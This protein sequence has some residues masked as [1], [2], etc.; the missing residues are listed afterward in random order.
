MKW[1]CNAQPVKVCVAQDAA[2]RSFG[3]SLQS[4]IH[5]ILGCLLGSLD[6]EIN[7]GHIGCRDTES[8]PVQLPLQLGQNES[9]GLK[10]DELPVNEEKGAP[11]TAAAPVDV[12]TMLTAPA[13]AR[14]RS[15]C[16]R[17]QPS[18]AFTRLGWFVQDHL[19]TSVRMS[20]GHGSILH[21]K[22]F[23]EHLANTCHTIC[24]A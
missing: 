13:R 8:N 12:G 6:N 4:S 23:L 10:K 16:R 21:T 18:I 5:F 1:Q 11:H 9:N 22:L 19:V 3:S 14:R 24:G 2:E 15:L 17:W 20:C 7:D